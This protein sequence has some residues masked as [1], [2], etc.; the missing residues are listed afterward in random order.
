MQTDQIAHAI[1]V[2]ISNPPMALMDIA[3]VEDLVGAAEAV[4]LQRLH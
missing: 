1:V 3:I 4:N 2:T